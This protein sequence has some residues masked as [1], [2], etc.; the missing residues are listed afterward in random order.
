M[1]GRAEST[2]LLVMKDGKA[3]GTTYAGGHC[4]E[5]GWVDPCYAP[6]HE[7]QYVKSPMDVV[8]GTNRL[9]YGKDLEGAELVKV[10]R[11]T[12]VEEIS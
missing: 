4:H 12:Y 11:V 2:G 8:G 10:K 9:I 5:E 6:L 7:E 3:W 1:I